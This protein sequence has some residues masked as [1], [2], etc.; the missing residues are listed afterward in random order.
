MRLLTI[1][2]TGWGRQKLQKF[3]DSSERQA[4]RSLQIHASKDVLANSDKILVETNHWIQQLLMLLLNFTRKIGLA[5]FRLTSQ[6][7][8]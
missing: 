2:P 7:L 1:A 6:M 3:L 8:C 5:E 4:R